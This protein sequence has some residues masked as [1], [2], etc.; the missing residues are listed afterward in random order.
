MLVAGLLVELPYLPC[1][2]AVMELIPKLDDVLIVEAKD[3]KGE[4][5]EVEDGIEVVLEP[6]R[7]GIDA[8]SKESTSDGGCGGNGGG[9]KSCTIKG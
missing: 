6:N 7:K 3:E 1:D 9:R 5:P 8:E 2:D 4:D